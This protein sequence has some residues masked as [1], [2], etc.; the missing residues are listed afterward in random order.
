MSN[1]TGNVGFGV[2]V[3]RDKLEQKA[4]GPP[5]SPTVRSAVLQQGNEF[6]CTT[7]SGYS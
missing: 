5:G 4:M 6:S 3:I 1:N 2:M 7:E